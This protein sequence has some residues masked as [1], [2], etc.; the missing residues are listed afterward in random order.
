MSYARFGWD[1]SDVY[2]FGTRR[3][4]LEGFECCGCYLVEARWVED[5]NAFLGGYLESVNPEESIS[6]FTYSNVE[7]IDHLIEHREAGHG[8]PDRTFSELAGEHEWGET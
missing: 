7:M 4:G 8:V 5:E 2:V 3:D 1:G 6:F